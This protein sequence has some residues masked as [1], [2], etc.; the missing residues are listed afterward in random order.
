MTLILSILGRKGGITKTTVAVNLSA[1]L[2]LEGLFT[3]LIEADGQSNASAHMGIDARD[4]FA[5]LMLGKREWADV[6]LPVPETFAGRP[7]E[8]LALSAADL[9]REVEENPGTPARLVK[10]LSSLRGWADVIIIDTSPGITHIHTGCFLASDVVLLPTLCE[11]DSIESVSKTLTY[12]ERSALTDERMG[13]A[14]GVVGI[15]PNRLKRSGQIGW[16]NHGMVKGRFAHT[17]HVFPPVFENPV[18]ALA[19]ANHQS[20]YAYKPK[21]DRLKRALRAA[22]D[23]FAPVVERVAAMARQTNLV[24]SSLPEVQEPA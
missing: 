13:K 21:E 2:A 10:S 1:K 11:L 12:L 14:A 19:R 24:S 5:E 16:E 15:L 17:Y 18:W 3:V 6:L 23:D 9:T 4:L 8:L 7:V 22:K 20:I